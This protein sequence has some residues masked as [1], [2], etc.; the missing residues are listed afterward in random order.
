MSIR[1]L[2]FRLTVLFSITLELDWSSSSPLPSTG[3]VCSGAP[4]ASVPNSLVN[5]AYDGALGSTVEIDCAA[6][7]Q[8]SQA[9]GGGGT[10]IHVVCSPYN[11]TDGVWS[12]PT[13]SCSGMPSRAHFPLYRI[14]KTYFINLF[15]N[16]LIL[17]LCV[18]QL[19]AHRVC[20]DRLINRN[21]IFKYKKIII[22]LKP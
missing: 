17:H 2:G 6:G 10:G 22:N 15:R 7:F 11:A 19:A 1:A 3:L 5:A 9:A 18:Q 20:E 14:R 12:S 4:N 21:Q 16:Y 8:S 13:G